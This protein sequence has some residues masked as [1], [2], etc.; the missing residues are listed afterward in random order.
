MAKNLD[1]TDGHLDGAI[2]GRSQFVR[3]DGHP[4]ER[5]TANGQFLNVKHDKAPFKSVRRE[6]H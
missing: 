3:P 1:K 4:V 2:K 6:K 5:D